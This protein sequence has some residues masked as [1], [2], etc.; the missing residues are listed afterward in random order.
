MKCQGF[1]MDTLMGF[2]VVADF[3]DFYATRKMGVFA[4]W[5]AVKAKPVTDEFNNVEW[6]MGS[7]QAKESITTEQL[8]EKFEEYLKENI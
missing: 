6:R 2:S 1:S 7:Y 8:L 5:L 3:A 4:D